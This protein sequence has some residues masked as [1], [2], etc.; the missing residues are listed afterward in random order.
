MVAVDAH[1]LARP[2]ARPLPAEVTAAPVAAGVKALV[3]AARRAHDRGDLVERDQLLDEADE[4]LGLMIEAL[5][6]EARRP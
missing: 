5:P 1:R 2:A 4:Q 6:D 3:R